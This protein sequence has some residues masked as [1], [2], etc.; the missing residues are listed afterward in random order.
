MKRNSPNRPPEW[1]PPDLDQL[2]LRFRVGDSILTEFVLG[3]DP[4]ATFRELV[5]NEYD[6]GGRSLEV[7]FGEN[8]LEVTG[9]GASIDRKGW[10]RLSVSLVNIEQA[11][12]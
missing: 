7:T 1:L 5:Q 10:R 12:A 4:A 6:A 9:N 8:A 3:H 11:I 2:D